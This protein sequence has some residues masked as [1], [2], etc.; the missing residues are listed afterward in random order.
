MYGATQTNSESAFHEKAYHT[1][2]SDAKGVANNDE[3]HDAQ[4]ASW[5]SLL[6]TK[7]AF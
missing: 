6:F 5:V 7:N 2:E 1:P 4:L 3:T